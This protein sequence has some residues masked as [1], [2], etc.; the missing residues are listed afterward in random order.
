[1]RIDEV[2]ELIEH[3]RLEVYSLRLELSSLQSDDIKNYLEEEFS[4][5]SFDAQG[6]AT[7]L[8]PKPY[9]INLLFDNVHGLYPLFK[10]LKVEADVDFFD[11]K[12]VDIHPPI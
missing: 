6:D 3:S 11:E 5:V 7:F 12:D 10:K 2:K 9:E 1:M 4:S 8:R